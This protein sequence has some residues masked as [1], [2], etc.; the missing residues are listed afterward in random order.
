MS[1]IFPVLN[2][3][4]CRIRQ[5]IP[6]WNTLFKKGCV[7]AAVLTLPNTSLYQVVTYA[8]SVTVAVAVFS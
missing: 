8:V 7:S 6:N 1:T 3:Y 4:V 2:S 5:S